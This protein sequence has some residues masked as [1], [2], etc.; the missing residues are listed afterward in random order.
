MSE[1]ALPPTLWAETAPAPPPTGPLA[2]PARADVVVIGGGFTGLSTALHLAEGGA[3]TL[4][5][6][7]GPIGFGASGRN[8]GLVI[9]TLSRLDPDDI[10]ASV[11]AALGGRE[12]GEELVGLIRDSAGFVFDLIR[13][14]GIEAEAVQKGWFQ[15]AHRPSR[16]ALARR[17]VEQWARRGAPVRLLDR[18]EAAARAGSEFWHGGWENSTGGHVNPLALARGLAAAAVGAG[19]RLH[20]QS[21]ALSIGRDLSIGS[22]GPRWRVTTPGG[23]VV[24]ERV[25]LAT[26]AY[27]PPGLW[28]GFERS[29]VPVRSYQMATTPLSDNLRRSILP[30]NHALSDTQGDLY[31]FHFDAAGRLVTGGSL[32]I[33]FG[34]EGR[35]RRRIAARVRKVYPQIGEFGFTHVWW[36][37]IAAT[38]DKA[39]H[40]YDLAPGVLGWSGCNGR[41]VALSIALGREMARASLGASLREVAAPVEQLRRI[42]GHSFAP[43]GVAWNQALFRWKDGRD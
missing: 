22:D 34:W 42:A 40:L 2:G 3:D 8:N 38:D 17:R 28:P 18:A 25:I 6:E 23:E 39:P 20:T 14:H 7:A 27:T 29:I 9:P 4:L 31:F 30:E 21:P 13:R 10:A 12:K 36:G 37:Y 1:L 26:H 33:P 43:L 16:M 15:P 5:L 32:I 19:A 35:L 11:P 41:G 24:A